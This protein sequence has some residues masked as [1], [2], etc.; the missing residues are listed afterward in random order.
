MFAGFAYVV[1]GANEGDKVA[2]GTFRNRA[3]ALTR[4]S[5][6]VNEDHLDGRGDTR[7]DYTIWETTCDMLA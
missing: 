6:L 2:L 1:F 7:A 5:F 3:D 4:I